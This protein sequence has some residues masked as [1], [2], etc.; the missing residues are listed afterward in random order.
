MAY[1]FDLYFL[2]F[3]TIKYDMKTAP[4]IVKNSI[5]ENRLPLNVSSLR[6]HRQYLGKTHL[7]ENAH[8]IYK[9][10]QY[11]C[12]NCIWYTCSYDKCVW[13]MS[14]YNKRF[15][16]QYARFHILPVDLHFETVLVSWYPHHVIDYFE[17]WICGVNRS[18][19]SFT[20]DRSNKYKVVKHFYSYT[21]TQSTWSVAV[22]LLK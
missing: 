18:D 5:K 15:D 2:L 12:F 3:I 13:D 6:K 14:Q 1:F 17:W 21:H 19:K 7:C 8:F 9:I 11:T 22:H 20:G 10:L 16:I 4:K